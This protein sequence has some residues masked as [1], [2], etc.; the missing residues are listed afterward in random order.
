MP[1]GRIVFAPGDVQLVTREGTFGN[2][3]RT[4]EETRVFVVACA[5]LGDE[6][7]EGLILNLYVPGVWTTESFTAEDVARMLRARQRERASFDYGFAAPDPSTGA[8]QYF[9][10]RTALQPEE[11]TGQAW[12]VKVAP[13]GDSVYSL[14]HT[15]TFQGPPDLLSEPMRS[16][17]AE[18]LEKK[19]D[20]ALTIEPAEEWLGIARGAR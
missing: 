10:A 18:S 14:L 12:L 2:C 4:L 16:W 9:V 11:Q 6:Q 20:P 13:L 5:K 8:L 15:R 19:D 17:L 1:A 7:E 3:E